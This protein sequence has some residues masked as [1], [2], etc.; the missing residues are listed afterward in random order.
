MQKYVVTNKAQSVLLFMKYAY[1]IVLKWTQCNPKIICIYKNL[2]AIHD[3]VR[4][5]NTKTK[6]QKKYGVE[7][8]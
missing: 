3:Y 6:W 7:I 5:Q 2:V 4:C 8:Y 1:F